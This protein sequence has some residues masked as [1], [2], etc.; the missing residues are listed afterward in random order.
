[1]A[2]LVLIRAPLRMADDREARA[3]FLDHRRRD[4]AG[5][6]A[7]I[8]LVHVLRPDR[9][10]RNAPRLYPLGSRRDQRERHRHRH[11]DTGCRRRCRRNRIEFRQRRSRPVHLPIACHKLAPH[12]HLPVVL[13]TDNAASPTHKSEPDRRGTQPRLE[14]CPPAP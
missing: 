10:R 7:A 1:M 9:E 8:R 6:R 13:P 12:H 2:R 3:D 14:A 11:V 4:A 5:M